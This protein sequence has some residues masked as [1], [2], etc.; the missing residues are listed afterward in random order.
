MEEV[1]EV[2]AGAG[3]VVGGTEAGKSGGC[4]LVVQLLSDTV[5]FKLRGACLCVSMIFF[6]VFYVLPT[7][8]CMHDYYIIM[9]LLYDPFLLPFLFFL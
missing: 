5:W 9:P 6:V 3:K 1:P 2:V 8:F 4:S 7:I